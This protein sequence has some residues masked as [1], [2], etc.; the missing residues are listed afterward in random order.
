M[1]DVRSIR[2]TARA[3]RSWTSGGFTL[4]ELVA[5]LVVTA[6]LAATAV[7]ALG[8]LADTRRGLAASGLRRDLT[9][10]RQRAV[11]TGTRSWVIFDVNAETWSLL[12]EDPSSPGRAGA[13][14][15]ADPGTGRDHVVQLGAGAFGGVTL[16][17][18]D[19]DGG[20]EIGF[21]WLGRPL[22]GA[23]SDLA[24]AGT[25]TLSGGGQVVVAATTG[26]VS[27]TP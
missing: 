7:P 11:A 15:L 10:A 16:A 14:A 1:S 22:N 20:V 18:A 24:A 27:V 8:T 13:V 25:V 17:S 3:R 2:T 9:L 26:H 5:V 6:I 12:V 4:V 19:F 21:D 23:E